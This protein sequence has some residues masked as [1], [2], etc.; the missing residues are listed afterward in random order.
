MI[1]KLAFAF[2]LFVSP[3]LLCQVHTVGLHQ[4]DLSTMDVGWG[5]PK[6]N[7]SVDGNRLA[8]AGRTFEHGVGTHAFSR[9]LINLNAA[10][11]RFRSHV[12]IDDETR[13][14]GSSEFVVLGDK[15]ILWRSGVMKAGDSARSAD[16]DLSGIR[17]LGLLVTDGG[18]NINYDHADWCDAVI[19]MKESRTAKELAVAAQAQDVAPSILTP[20]AKETPKINGPTIFGARPGSPFLYTI[21]ATG[22]RPMTYSVTDL[23]KGLACDPTTGHI[24]G[25][26]GNAGTYTVTLV[27][28][29]GLG[30][31][32]RSLRIVIGDKVALTPPLGWNSWNCW[33]GSV[34]A[35]KVR[36]SAGAM[37]EKGLRDHGWMYINIDDTWQGL[38]GGY[39]GAIQPNHKFPDM[40]SLSD[41][42]HSLGLKLGIYSTPW[43]TSYAL[44]AGGSSDSPEGVWTKDSMANSRHWRHGAYTFE[45]RDAKQWAEWGIDYLKYDWN[46][47]NV[48]AVVRMQKALRESGRDIVYSLS[49]SAPF[50]NADTWARTANCWRTTGDIIDT[51]ASM[52]RIGFSQDRWHPF[53]GPGH[54]N[55]PDMLV[56]GLVGWGPDLHPTRLTP[57]E[58]YT[59]ISLWALL[60]APLLLGCDLARLDEFTLGLLTNDEVLGIQQDALGR[61]ARQI[62]HD[63]GTEVWLKELE[64]GS[65]AAGLFFTGDDLRDPVTAFNWDRVTR[66]SVTMSLPKSGTHKAFTVRDVWR[67]KDLGTFEETFTAEVPYHG[68]VLVSITPVK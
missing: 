25:T 56:V 49:N 54:W 9:M 55:D 60:S 35:D 38:R 17:L 63:G 2:L 59:H 30:K 24:S 31:D 13:K 16:V 68:V 18:D 41:E 67:Q 21:P 50:E 14:R 39:F 29:N 5:S 51:W 36:A 48:E 6:A 45:Q 11:T 46:P 44:Y 52:S 12:G 26:V 33:A 1:M 37:V 22:N 43:I 15:R 66:K 8:I 64:E 53:A 4:L 57:D 47:N 19:E 58:Q 61:Q 10:G 32:E 40:K 62:E 42:I 20:P 3:A 34:D 27:V 65:Y 7:V 28:T 23:P